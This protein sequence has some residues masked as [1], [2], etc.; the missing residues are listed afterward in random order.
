MFSTFFGGNDKSWA[1]PK[2]QYVDFTNF[3]FHAEAAR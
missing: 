2:D 3:R 1:S